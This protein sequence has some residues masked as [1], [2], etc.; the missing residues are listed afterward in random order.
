MCIEDFASSHSPTAEYGA[1]AALHPS[2]PIH[3]QCFGQLRITH[4]ERLLSPGRSRLARQHE[5]LLRVVAAGPVG[6]NAERLA[7]ELWPLADPAQ[8]RQTLHTTLSRI[9][10][11]FD[12]ES[13]LAS[14]GPLLHINS[15]I[16]RVDSIDLER[17]LREILLPLQQSRSPAQLADLRGRL[18]TLAH[19]VFLPELSRES[20]VLAARERIAQDVERAVRRLASVTD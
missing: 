15:Q 12:G 5:V 4:G 7:A 16:A 2:P 3:I 8:R 18:D 6:L 11:D 10:K 1:E 19:G 9:R 17:L 13:P 14:A 20:W